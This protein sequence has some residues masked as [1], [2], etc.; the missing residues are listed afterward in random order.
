MNEKARSAKTQDDDE[1]A[2]ATKR[3]IRSERFDERH[4]KWSSYKEHKGNALAPR[5]DE[6][7]D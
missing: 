2:R 6:G 3:L 7:R 5:A 1:R 4:L